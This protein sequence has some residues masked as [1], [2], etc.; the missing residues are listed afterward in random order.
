LIV[1][2]LPNPSYAFMVECL[3][4]IKLSDFSKDCDQY[5]SFFLL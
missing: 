5:I 3:E 4:I 2:Y 1:M